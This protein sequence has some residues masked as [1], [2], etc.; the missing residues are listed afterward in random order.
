MQPLRRALVYL[1][2]Y[3]RTTLGAL[4]SLLLV[5]GANLAS[6]QV[7]RL[8][9]DQ[10]M[11]PAAVAVSTPRPRGVEFDALGHLVPQDQR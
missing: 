2:P 8:I 5:T 11:D 10:G 7:L 3:W 1:R 6:P 9:I 4:L